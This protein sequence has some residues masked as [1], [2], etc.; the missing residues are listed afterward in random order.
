VAERLLGFIER[1]EE[2][3]AFDEGELDAEPPP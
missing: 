3:G 2:Q 1:G